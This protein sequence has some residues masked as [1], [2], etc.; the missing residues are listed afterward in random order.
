MRSAAPASQ[1]SRCVGGRQ[2]SPQPA[3][4]RS[5]Q[6]LRRVHH[7]VRAGGGHLLGTNDQFYEVLSRCIW[8]ARTALEVVVLSVLVSVVIGALLGL[9]SGFVGGWTDRFLVFFTERIF[10]EDRLIVEQEQAAHDAQGA[11]WN[12]EVF[13]PILD[14]RALLAARGV[15]L[16]PAPA[17]FQGAGA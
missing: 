2:R 5:A 9:V 3:H 13:P 4:H 14:L 11:D 6:V 16:A 7:G 1:R 15:P 17:S 8:G 10:R 12:Q